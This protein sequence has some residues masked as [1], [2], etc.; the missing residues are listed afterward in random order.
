MLD[1]TSRTFPTTQLRRLRGQYLAKNRLDAR[2]RARLAVDILDRRAELGDLTVKQ[3]GWLCRVSVKTISVVRKSP[4]DR[5]VAAWNEASNSQRI[6]FAERVGVSK[7][8]DEA[9]LPALG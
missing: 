9:I 8:W 5:L 6:E 4:S 3:V 1:S 2:A 7:V